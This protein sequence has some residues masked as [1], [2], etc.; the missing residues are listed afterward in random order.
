M[1]YLSKGTVLH[2]PDGGGYILTRDVDYGELMRASQFEAFGGVEPARGGEITPKWLWAEMDRAHREEHGMKQND[3]LVQMEDGT[4]DKAI[5]ANLP[6]TWS[7]RIV[8]RVK[9]MLEV[10][11]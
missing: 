6:A 4:W 5:P 8:E 9:A 11:R 3:T 10:L 7:E 2:C 1:P